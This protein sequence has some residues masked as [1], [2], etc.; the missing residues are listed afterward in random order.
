MRIFCCLVRQKYQRHGHSITVTVSRH[1]VS[2]V[3]SHRPV[4]SASSSMKQQQSFWNRGSNKKTATHIPDSFEKLTA[5]TWDC[6]YVPLFRRLGLCHQFTSHLGNIRL[7]V[8][9]T[10]IFLC[11]LSPHQLFIYKPFPPC[12]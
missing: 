3:T 2:S 7:K 8:R 9:K 11:P 1:S 4:T 10:V 5:S 6:Y 12:D